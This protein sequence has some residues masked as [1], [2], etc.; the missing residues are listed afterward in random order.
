MLQDLCLRCCHLGVCPS[1]GEHVLPIKARR[2]SV[3]LCRRA[4]RC[5]ACSIRRCLS[6]IPRRPHSTRPAGAARRRQRHP[7][8]PPRPTKTL[9]LSRLAFLAA[10]PPP[11]F[12][13]MPTTTR[14]TPAPLPRKPS[15]S[16][17]GTLLRLRL[18]RCWPPPRLA[19]PWTLA[20]WRW[21]KRFS[22]HR[23]LRRP[24]TFSSCTR[25]TAREYRASIGP[26]L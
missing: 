13:L 2:L 6:S 11:A 17:A 15:A 23:G 19:W 25:A 5:R 24:V 10:T 12:P 20:S 26:D 18:A 16:S 4:L 9:W 14:Q 22:A 3:A 7:S 8:P 1:E 21:R